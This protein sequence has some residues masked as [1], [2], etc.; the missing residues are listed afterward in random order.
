MLGQLW[1]LITRP[2]KY[3]PIAIRDAQ[4][5]FAPRMVNSAFFLQGQMDINPRCKWHRPD[6]I[7]QTGGYFVPGDPIKREIAPFYP[8]DLVRRDMLILLMRSLNERRIEGEMAE[9]GTWQGI[10]AKV[11]HYYMPDRPLHLFDTF[12]GFDERDIHSEAQ[13]TGLKASTKEFSDTSVEGV[14]NYIKP[15]NGNVHIHQGFFPASVPKDFG[16][17][18]FALVHLDADLYDPILAGLE[19]FYPR[20]TQGG[21]I[22]VHDYNAW[23]GARHAAE[24]FLKGKAEVG[25]PMPDKSG[26]MVITK[27]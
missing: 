22:I 17:K 20:M 16:M 15:Q 21:F 8:W 23:P 11:F 4:E 27:L 26:S 12:A 19:Y 10:S 25:V 6:F 3:L 1:K 5:R 7:K 9:L 13:K 24:D 18:K 14:L 2:G